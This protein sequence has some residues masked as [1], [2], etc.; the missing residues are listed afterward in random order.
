V[1]S[2]LR[3][4]IKQ[5]DDHY[6]DEHT[7]FTQ[8]VLRRVDV[9]DDEL[10][11]IDDAVRNG[12]VQGVLS[13]DSSDDEQEVDDGMRISKGGDTFDSMEAQQEGDV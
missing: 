8:A 1:P 5:L 4:A 6:P 13:D 12:L 7:D 2:Q 3:V 10:Q 11:Q 9:P